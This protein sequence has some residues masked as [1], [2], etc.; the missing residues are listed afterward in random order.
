[1]DLKDLLIKKEYGF[2]ESFAQKMTSSK[3]RRLQLFDIDLFDYVNIQCWEKCGIEP[4]T[5]I[6]Q[7]ASCDE[8][9]CPIA[10]INLAVIKLGM[11]ENLLNKLEITGENIEVK[12][13]KDNDNE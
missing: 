13:R 6:Y 12:F 10:H 1:M 3:D 2:S 5:D 7:G 11:L 9:D 8:C 4:S